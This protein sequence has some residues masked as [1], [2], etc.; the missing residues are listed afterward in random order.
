[1]VKRRSD[2]CHMQHYTSLLRSIEIIYGVFNKDSKSSG[3]LKRLGGMVY[4]IDSQ[5]NQ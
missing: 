4:K 2:I 5:V 1:M 3:S